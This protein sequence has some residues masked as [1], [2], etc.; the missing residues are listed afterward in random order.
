MFENPKNDG[1]FSTG[2]LLQK[3]KKQSLYKIWLII[4]LQG[5]I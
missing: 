3:V 2:I 5:V 4:L 1:M